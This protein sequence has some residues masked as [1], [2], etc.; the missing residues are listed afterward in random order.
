MKTEMNKKI[1][2][3][4][5]EDLPT[6][7]EL[8]EHELKRGNV[9]FE[10]LLVS[11]KRDYE[12]ALDVFCPHIVLSDHSLPT[13]DSIGALNVIKEKKINI[14]FILITATV[15]E[16][17]AVEIIKK[18]ASDYILKDRLQRLPGAIMHALEINHAE[19]ARRA[20]EEDL[21]KSEARLKEAQA[22]G[23]ISNWE[24]DMVTNV[25]IWSD[26]FYNTFGITKGETEPSPEAF[27]SLIHPDDKAFAAGKVKHAFETLE[28]SNF[29]FRF[30]RKDGSLRNAYAEW[31][32]EYDSNRKPIRLYGILQDITERKKAERELRVMHDRLSFHMENTPLGFIEWDEQLNMKSMSKQAEKIFGWNLKDFEEH[33]R[34]GYSQVYEEDQSI[35]FGIAEQLLKGEVERNNIRHRN[36]R[37]DGNV[38]WCEWFNSVLRDNNGKVITIMSL[39]QDITE[40]K[41]AEEKLEQQ[42]KELLKTNSELDRFVYSTSHDLRAPLSS[43]LGLI[44]LVNDEMSSDDSLQKERL[45]MMKQSVIKLD[46]FIEDILHYSRNA[47]LETA[48]EDIVF[49]D[50]IREARSNHKFMEGT[51]GLNLQAEINQKQRFVSDKRRISVIMNNLISNAVKYRDASKEKSFVRVIIQSDDKNATIVVEDN[52]IG[53]AEKDKEK[54]FEMF[55]R[56]SK[57]SSGS[58]LGLYIVKETIEKL[59]ATITLQSQKA[60]GTIFTVIIPNSL[61]NESD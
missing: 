28:N 61:N 9:E 13:F 44:E 47:R 6:D 55:Y 34:S 11:N 30:L 60:T 24:V 39:V 2:I 59:K 53:I 46:T 54:V 4:H 7:A 5:L 33:R 51:S 25:N 37:K 29:N 21:K 18:G 38:I 50:I 20:A 40:R 26:E 42:N 22:I 15:S 14:P 10:Y 57:Q 52:G 1:K 8:V 31:R 17:F 32:F 56:G 45:V 12:K 43:M 48:K 23:H 58:G 19:K 36:Y 35:V 49:E 41:E 3:L 27:L 16:E